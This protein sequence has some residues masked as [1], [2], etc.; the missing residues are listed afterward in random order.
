MGNVMELPRD[1]VR[2]PV[3]EPPSASCAL[4]G[5]DPPGRRTLCRFVCCFFRG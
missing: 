1:G 2:E 4:D 5:G 3:S